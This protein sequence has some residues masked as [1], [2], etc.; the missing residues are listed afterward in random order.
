MTTDENANELIKSLETAKYLTFFSDFQRETMFS[1]S[2]HVLTNRFIDMCSEVSMVQR[3]GM[4]T[5]G[6]LVET[7]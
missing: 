3:K 1:E 4:L 7:T 2:G 5:E 6:P